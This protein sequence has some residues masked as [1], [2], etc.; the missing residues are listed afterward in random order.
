MD[1]LFSCLNDEP[2]SLVLVLPACAFAGFIITVRFSTIQV[3]RF[4]AF[5]CVASLLGNVTRFLF[6]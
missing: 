4:I 3:Q 5:G 1:L 6:A 2:D